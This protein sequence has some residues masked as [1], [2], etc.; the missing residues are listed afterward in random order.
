[1]FS[2]HR[3]LSSGL[4]LL[5]LW[6]SAAAE[7]AALTKEDLAAAVRTDDFTIPT[8]GEFMAAIDKFAKLAWKTKYRASIPTNFTSRPQMALNLGTLIADGY[9]AVQAQDA[10]TVKN[11]GK[12]I[13]AL[14]KPLGVQAEIVNRGKRLAE[15]AEDEQWDVLKEELE[16]TQNEAKTKLADNQDADLVALVT[17]GG[18]VR[19]TQVISSHIIDHYSPAAAKLLRQPGVV[20]LLVEKLNALPAKLHDD[21]AVKY[22]RAKLAELQTAVSFATDAEPSAA[23]VQKINTIAAELVREL[24]KKELK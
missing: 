23:D 8:P 20:T 13:I 24:S 9:I 15:L 6:A 16:A 2:T 18:W 7:P 11:V 17:I 21:V 5:S 10:Q 14:A 1:M 12:D 19:A 4:A 3:T 22:T